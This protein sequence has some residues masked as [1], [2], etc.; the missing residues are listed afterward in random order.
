MD[1]HTACEEAYKRG[2]E[3]GKAD[4]IN[5]YSDLGK[6]YSEI[7]AEAVKEALEKAKEATYNY[8]DSAID[9]IAKEMGV[10][11]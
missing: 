10:E 5:Q 6:L 7:R 2:Y 11:L 9:K 8:Y 1:I 3:R 4:G